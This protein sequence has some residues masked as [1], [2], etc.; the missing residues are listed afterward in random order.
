[1]LLVDD[2]EPQEYELNLN[3]T[4]SVVCLAYTRPK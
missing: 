4:M 2:M 1:M 3:A